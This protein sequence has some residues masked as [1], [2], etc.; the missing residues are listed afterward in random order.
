MSALQFGTAYYPEHWPESRWPVDIALMKEAGMTVV[1]M[2][3]FAWSSLEPAPG[4]FHFDWLE[5]AIGMLAE[6]GIQTVLGTPTAAP[7]I[8][9][10]EQY[11]SILPVKENGQR[12]QF[13]NRCHYC[14]NAKEVHFA[15]QR[16]VEAMAERLGKNPHVI[17]WQI[18][19][20]FNRVCFCDRCQAQFQAFL[21]ERYG[22]IEALNQAWSTAYWS[23]IYSS[24]TQIPLPHEASTFPGVYHNPGLLLEF[25]R[26]ITASYRAF[27]K[28]QVDV[29]RPRLHSAAWVTHNFMEWFDGFDH[30]ELSADLDLASWDWYIGS[31]RHDHYRNG[32]AHDLVRGFKRKNFWLMETQPGNVNWAPVSNMLRQGE[33]RAMAWHAVGHGAEALL[34]WQWRSAPGGQ[35]QYHGSL[36]DQSGQP[37]PFYEEASQIGREFR[38]ISKL[39]EGSTIK[40]RVA[41]LNCYE[42]RWSLEWQRQQGD[43]DYV[44]YLESLYHPLAAC[45]L[46]VDILSADEP[47]DGYR[48]VIA[49]A[50]TILDVKRVE[51]LEQFVNRGGHL[52]LTP[53]TGMKDR[54]NALL[55]VRQPGGLA[56]IAGVEVEEYYPLDENVPVI[57]NIIGQ[58]KAY[59]WA[60]RLRILDEKNTIVAARYGESNGWLEERPAITVHSQGN[61]LVYMLAASLDDRSQETFIKH[62]VNMAGLYPL[63]TPP[64]VEICTRARTDGQS[65]YLIIN[66][67]KHEQRITLPW[68]AYDHLSQSKSGKELLLPGYGVLIVTRDGG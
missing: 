59:P 38:S 57:G 37:R 22:T 35:E 43:F 56:A 52:V 46:P 53:R 23:Q 27:Q 2:A 3:E 12:V 29:L 49:P 20:E 19:N 51:S 62:V 9:L 40:A 63:D 50:L 58:G 48:L 44:K 18:D 68:P 28:L 11:P 61:G 55:S 65:V 16:I 41:I 45:N 13:G 21:A 8:W 4:I 64:G 60:E 6:A 39:L 47:L 1:R 25:K 32:A 33:A 30:Y 15:A 7:P 10:V 31:G 54:A 17:G 5:R 66:H 67:K 14:V 34:Y 24:W 42:S 36:I 26:F